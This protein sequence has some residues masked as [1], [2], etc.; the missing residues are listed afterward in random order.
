[1]TSSA[2]TSALLSLCDYDTEILVEN[3]GGAVRCKCSH[4]GGLKT[5]LIGNATF[6]ERGEVN[7]IGKGFAFERRE[8]ITDE[9]E[10]WNNFLKSR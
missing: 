2:T 1:M 8:V 3:R 10:A 7:V 5:T 4:E 9:I 6:T